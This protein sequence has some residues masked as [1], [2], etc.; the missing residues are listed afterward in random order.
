MR[1]AY[2]NSAAL[3]GEA[4]YTLTDGITGWIARTGRAFVARTSE[5]IYSHPAWNDKYR[6]RKFRSPKQCTSL[7][8]VPLRVGGRTLGVLE[9]ENGRSTADHL[10]TY[11]GPDE[12]RILF[13]LA[14][15]VAVLI[16]HVRLREDVLREREQALQQAVDSVA[17]DTAH[18]IGTA[19][20]P[21]TTHIA[22][23]RD[24]LKASAHPTQH[25]LMEDISAIQESCEAAA[26]AVRKIREYSVPLRLVRRRILLNALAHKCLAEMLGRDGCFAVDDGGR[27]WYVTADRQQ[28]AHAF[29]ELLHNS[30][31][32][33]GSGLEVRIRIAAH[34]GDYVSVTVEDNGPGVPADYKTRIFDRHFSF[35][36]RS[37]ETGL[38]LHFV[39]K[40]VEAHGG[41]IAEVGDANTGAIFRILLPQ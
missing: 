8:G 36:T 41:R 39:K 5:E 9:V 21:A 24:S 20:L 34:R 11:F 22:I 31:K 32:M 37:R 19:L 6:H 18:S 13:A 33:T 3:V 28:I 15:V 14:G 40:I 2:G 12:E 7:L 23:L 30:M 27:K 1:A 17:A 25:E 29:R 4:T 35:G 38:G 10:Q 26:G 16:E